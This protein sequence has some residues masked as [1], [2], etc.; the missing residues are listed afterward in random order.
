MRSRVIEVSGGAEVEGLA[1]EQG[2]PAGD[3]AFLG[4]AEGV[5]QVLDGGLEGRAARTRGR[6]EA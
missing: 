3:E 5:A 2:W 1:F 4:E 6:S